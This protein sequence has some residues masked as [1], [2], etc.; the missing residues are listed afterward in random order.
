MNT[1]H[2]GTVYHVYASY[3]FIF[4]HFRDIASYLSKVANFSYPI[5][6]MSPGLGVMEFHQDPWHQREPIFPPQT[7]LLLTLI[8]D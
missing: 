3:A 8:G 7:N 5:W 1:N 2:L 4:Y 6:C